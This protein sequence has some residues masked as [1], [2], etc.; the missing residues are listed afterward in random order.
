MK[1]QFVKT[2][3]SEYSTIRRRRGRFRK[4]QSLFFRVLRHLCVLWSFKPQFISLKAKTKT[5]TWIVVSVWQGN[6]IIFIE[7]TIH[8]REWI[9]AATATYLLNELLTSN[10][11]NI[12]YLAN[13]YDFVIVPVMNVD[14]YVY[15][16]T[17]VSLRT[18]NCHGLF[19]WPQQNVLNFMLI[20][21][22]SE[23]NVAKN[24]TTKSRNKTMHWN[25]YE[26]KLWLSPRR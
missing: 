16:H 5:K 7:S 20:F 4:F 6:P 17:T 2:K 24:A 15:T 1:N 11:T 8:A 3:K 12:R 18:W 23:S 13:N 10:Q 19:I 21:I 9:T 14:G 25:W 22:V 26:Q